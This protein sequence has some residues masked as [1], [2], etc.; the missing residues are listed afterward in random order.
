MRCWTGL[1]RPLLQKRLRSA[2]ECM[3]LNNFVIRI[4]FNIVFTQ[5]IFI[6]AFF[7]DV[8]FLHFIM[9]HSGHDFSVNSFKSYGTRNLLSAKELNQIHFQCK[10]VMEF[11]FVILQNSLTSHKKL[12]SSRHTDNQI[13]CSFI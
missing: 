12:F 13:V 8:I 9:R 7:H 10:K 5:N 1:P 2:Y 11:N 4:V 3:I 6:P